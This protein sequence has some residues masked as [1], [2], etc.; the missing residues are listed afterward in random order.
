MRGSRGKGDTPPSQKDKCHSQNLVPHEWIHDSLDFSLKN[1]V[2]GH[3][4]GS[5][6][7]HLPL[8]QGVI[9][10]S[11]DWVPHWAPCVEPASSSA[12]VSASLSLS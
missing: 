4:G 10:E 7:N 12:C 8:A 3:L 5:G 11:W 1:P 2:W 9:L 6:V